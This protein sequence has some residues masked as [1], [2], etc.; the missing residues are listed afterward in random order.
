MTD[1]YH[2]VLVTKYSTLQIHDMFDEVLVYFLYNYYIYENNSPFHISDTPTLST[3]HISARFE[4][5]SRKIPKGAGEV[6]NS[7]RAQLCIV[8]IEVFQQV[9]TVGFAFRL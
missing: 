1:V 4:P 7:A 5:R 6:I 8:F 3:N 9:P 2:I